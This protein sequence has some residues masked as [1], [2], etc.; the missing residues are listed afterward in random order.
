MSDMKKIKVSIVI[1]LILFPVLFCGIRYG[2]THS[3]ENDIETVATEEVVDSTV[4]MTELP[5]DYMVDNSFESHLPLVVIDLGGDEIPVAYQYN[6]EK[7][8]VEP[9]EGVTP[10]IEGNIYLYDSGNINTLSDE[11]TEQS[12]MEIKYRGNSS[13]GYDKKQYK[14]KLL[15]EDGN[16]NKLSLLGLGEDDEWILNISM[17]D[18]S[19]V[20]NYLAYTV[21]GEIDEY[22]PDVKYCEVLF[23]YGDKYEYE[24]LYLLMESVKKSEE[25]VAISDYDSQNDFSSYL[26][27]RDRYDPEAVTL[28]T[29]ATEL[30]LSYGTLS[31]KY[32]SSSKITDDTKSYIEEQI[33]RIEELLYS[34][35]VTD[36]EKV[37]AYIDMDSFVDYFL[38]NE[39]FGNYDAGNNSTYLYCEAGGKLHIGPVWDFDGAMD[40]YSGE[41][42]NPDEIVMC[43]RTWFDRLCLSQEFNKELLSRYKELRSTILS[44]EEIELL[45]DETVEYLGNAQLRDRCRWEESLEAY[46]LQ[47]MEDENEV[48]IDRN[49]DTYEGEI[50]R[51]KDNLYLHGNAIEGKLTELVEETKSNYG[52]K[53][54]SG[55]AII[56]LI[57]F[58]S[59]VVVIRRK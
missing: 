52:M 54:Y 49:M 9:I 51:V 57:A 42:T 29:Y 39:F 11:V 31:V 43:Y 19:L 6:K 27:K 25:R 37:S 20:R 41:I 15:D 48:L 45:I 44:D 32:P 55:W 23:K 24:G 10:Y 40:N 3:Q 50:Q 46:Q 2:L 7:D 33:D 38:L 8:Y 34:D 21:A 1:I 30:G 22:T 12:Q 58:L 47:I 28:D 35:D 14:V 4:G 17:A 36:I 13:L 56:F 59:S 53:T 5:E 18:K 26:L 16:D